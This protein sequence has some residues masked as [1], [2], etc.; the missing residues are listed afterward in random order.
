MQFLLKCQHKIGLI[1]DKKKL[2]A[3]VRRWG[4]MAATK[5]FDGLKGGEV[6]GAFQSQINQY[7]HS[8]F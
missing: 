8:V 1:Y 6:G 3:V 2:T 5:I 4:V 7:K